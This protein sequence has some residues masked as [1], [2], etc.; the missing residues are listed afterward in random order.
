MRAIGKQGVGLDR[1]DVDACASAG[2]EVF[3][4]PGVNSKAVAELVLALTM[5]V[6][7]EIGSIKLR[8]HQGETIPKEMCSGLLLSGKTLGLIGMGN[9]SREVAQ[10]FRGAFN[11]TIVASS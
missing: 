10:I 9:V 8:Q 3:N 5:S 11:A 2:I 4:T 6:A 1:V 7:R